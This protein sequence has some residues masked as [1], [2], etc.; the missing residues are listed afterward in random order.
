MLEYNLRAASII[1]Y[2]GA[3][4][5]GAQLA[6]YYEYQAWDKVATV[7]LFILALVTVL[8][9]LGEWMRRHITRSLGLRR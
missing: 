2:V 5:L 7:L 3:G 6:S 9:L 1:G 4:G 8:D